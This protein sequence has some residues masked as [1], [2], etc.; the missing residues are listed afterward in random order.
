MAKSNPSAR[1]GVERLIKSNMAGNS[2]GLICFYRMTASSS[3]RTAATRTVVTFRASG[4][5]TSTEHDDFI[6]PGNFGEDVARWLRDELRAR[7]FPVDEEI[8]QEDFGWYF[9][10]ACAGQKFDIVL[11]YQ[12]DDRIWIAWVERSVGLIATMFGR[13][14]RGVSLDPLI[15][16]HHVLSDA[17]RVRDVRWHRS[18]EFKAGDE[19][20]WAP[21]PGDAPGA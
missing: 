9:S 14:T 10:F 4:F 5:N 17:A 6:N 11:G 2:I 18:R 1:T 13:R 7:G 15:A 16:I 19:S 3:A 21:T 20:N 12:F 8:G